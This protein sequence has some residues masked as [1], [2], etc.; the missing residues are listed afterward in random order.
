MEL[1]Q[2][3][4]EKEGKKEPFLLGV[5]KG[6]ES[7]RS[8]FHNLSGALR[9]GLYRMLQSEY[10]SVRSRH[11]DADPGTDDGALSEQIALEYCSGGAEAEVCY[12]RGE[13]FRACLGEVSL[14]PEKDQAMAFPEGHV[15]WVTG[16]TRG[17]GFLCAAHLVRRCGVRKLVLTGRETL[18]LREEWSAW[19]RKSDSV[20]K[21]IRAIQAL[22]SEGVEVRVFSVELTD[23]SA[24]RRQLD[25]VR[26]DLGPI[27]GVLHCAGI[28]DEETPALIRKSLAGVRNVLDPKVTATDV[29]LDT[30]RDEPLAFMVLFSSVSAIVPRL[31]A[32]LSDYAM[33][34]AYMDYVAEANGHAFPV[35]SIQWSSWKD[36][37]MGEVKNEAY[38][39]SGFLR[40]MPKG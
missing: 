19:E 2:Q 7:F 37:G 13:R 15:L 28:L 16:G 23:A 18:P 39:Q 35:T 4:I 22:E 25:E 17:I 29:L 14:E 9:A 40:Q 30:F 33:A 27:G 21:K 1:V 38:A 26:R 31:A 10:P 8:S 24:M 5:T 34:N 20:A 12:R 11:M 3:L 36:T 32:G 6:L